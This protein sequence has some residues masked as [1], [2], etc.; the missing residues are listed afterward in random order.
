MGFDGYGPKS[1]LGAF[2]FTWPDGD[3]TQRPFKLPKVCAAVWLWGCGAVGLWAGSSKDDSRGSSR[4]TGF[5]RLVAQLMCLLP[6]LTV[7]VLVLCCCVCRC[8][9]TRMLCLMGWTTASSLGRVT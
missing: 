7:L 5:N 6:L 1:T 3:C 4:P 2:L 9:A 8:Q